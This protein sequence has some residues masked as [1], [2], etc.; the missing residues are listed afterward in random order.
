[1]IVHKVIR[2][3]IDDPSHRLA[4]FIRHGEKDTSEAGLVLITDKAKI[5]V[6]AMGLRFSGLN[7]PIKIYS[8]PELRCVETAKIFNREIS[9]G[10][11]DI[12]LTSFLGDPGAHIKNN[13]SYLNIFDKYGARKIYSQWKV[14]QHYDILKTPEE[15]QN[16]LV[17]FLK[18]MPSG[19]KI[20]LLVSQSGTVAALGYALGLL[21]YDTDKNEWVPFLEGFVIAY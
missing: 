18:K 4:V 13:D 8:S 7:I 10:S 11:D 12:V 3:L 1:M 20:S 14:G 19:N 21:D 16:E 17:D 9:A 15:L 2:K 5:N 6:K